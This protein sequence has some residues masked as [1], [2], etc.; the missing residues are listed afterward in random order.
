MLQHT[1]LHIKGIGEKTENDLWKKGIQTWQDFLE[2]KGIVFSP[3]RDR[4]I[5]DQLELS[6]KHVDDIRFFENRLASGEMWRLFEQFKNSCACLDIETGWDYQGV[7]EITLIG[8]FDG[9]SVQTF[10]NGVN[11]YEFELAIATYELLITFNGTCFD[12]PLIRRWFTSISLPPAHIDLRFLLKKLGFTGGLKKIEREF[13]LEREQEISG[14]GG[15]EAIMLWK[16][17]R[18]GKEGAL[19]KLISYNT[20]DTINLMP[21]MSQAYLGMKR[22]LLGK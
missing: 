7:G 12:L 17:Y 20:A 3:E 10:V 14:M 2:R 15:R 16:A 22:R 13:G 4:F 1:F 6:L 18:E 21:L 9:K 5:E 11:F 19:D 8:L